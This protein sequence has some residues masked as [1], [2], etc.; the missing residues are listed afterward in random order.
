MNLI[1]RIKHYLEEYKVIKQ[2]KKL[3]KKH[4]YLKLDNSYKSTWLDEIPYGWREL[5]LL[6]F[7]QIRN[8]LI[9]HNAIKYLQIT[10]IKEKYGKLRIYYSFVNCPNYENNKW[11]KNVSRLFKLLEKDSWNFCIDCGNSAK[12]QTNDYITP[13][14]DKCKEIIEKS[15]PNIKVSKKSK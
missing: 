15:Y 5:S 3:V 11:I 2:N 14:C 6:Y 9:S 1:D 10:E 12:Y 13:V 4:P 7:E 8:I